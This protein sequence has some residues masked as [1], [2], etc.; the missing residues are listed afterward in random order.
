MRR[1]KEETEHS[2]VPLGFNETE[3][4]GQ[5]GNPSHHPGFLLPP[6][7]HCFK[8]SRSQRLFW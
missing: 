1:A 4:V 7:S 8:A 5:R 3:S 2:Q 6:T